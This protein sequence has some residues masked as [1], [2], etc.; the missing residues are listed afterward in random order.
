MQD[1]NATKW[2][3]KSRGGSF[4]YLFFVK[5]L[6]FFGVRFAYFVLLFVA[7][8][9]IFF[10]PKATAVSWDYHRK[11]L[12]YGRLKSAISVYWHFYTFAQTIVDKLA[13]RIGLVDD[14]SFEYTN[15]ARFLELID[16]GSGV[17]MI[18]AHVGCGEAGAQFFGNLW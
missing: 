11:R 13:L 1:T 4:G 6:R 9:F 18:G 15:S 3:G 14:Y 2:D 10:A 5:A 16:S 12:G 7:F 17:V 8:Y